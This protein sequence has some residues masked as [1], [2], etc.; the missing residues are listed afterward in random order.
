MNDMRAIAEKHPELGGDV[1]ATARGTIT[2][3]FA[4]NFVFLFF[5]GGC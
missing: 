4:Y 2:L 1:Y 3:P 5:D